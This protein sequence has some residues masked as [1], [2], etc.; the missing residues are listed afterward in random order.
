MTS[1]GKVR[2]TWADGDYEFNVAKLG[3]RLELEEKCD[4]GTQLIFRR[5]QTG[6]ARF[7][8]I[9]ETI[10][11]G[12]IGGGMS[13]EEAVVLVRRYVDE[14][15]RAINSLIAASIL[16]AEI[17]GVEGDEPGKKDEAD[18]VNPEASRSS[19]KMSASADPLSTVSEQELDLPQDKS[20]KSPSGN[21]PPPLTDII[22]RKVPRNNPRQ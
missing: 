10:R 21:S 1:H 22:E 17:V 18:R 15:P 9:R 4:A 14:Q 8:D 11:L 3:I 7:N 6:E 19:E 16:A 2:L 20:M 12:L 5:I 13:P